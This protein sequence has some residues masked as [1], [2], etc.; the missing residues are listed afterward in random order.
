M[1]L[2]LF[3]PWRGRKSLLLRVFRK[4]APSW[5]ASPLRRLCQT[6]CLAAFLWLVFAGGRAV[7]SAD[8]PKAVWA[9]GLSLPQMFDPLVGPAASLAAWTLTTALAVGGGVLL[10]SLLLPRSFCGWVCPLGTLIDAAGKLRWWRGLVKGGRAGG[11]WT[12]LRFFVLAGAMLLSA[13][14][15]CGA[16]FGAIPILTRGLML[17]GVGQDWQHD[18]D[19]R[20]TGMVAG[21]ALAIILLV[22]LVRRR[23]WCRYVCPSGA[24]QSVLAP[25]QVFRRRVSSACVSCGQ[26]ARICEFGAIDG[27]DFSTLAGRCTF[28]Q[29]CG[30]VCPV[31]AIEFS[32][33]PRIKAEAP[34]A[35]SPQPAAAT[36][37]SAGTGLSRRVFIG[38]SAACLA[39][40]SGLTRLLAR[41]GGGNELIRPPGA[42]GPEQFDGLCLRCGTCIGVC[43]SGVIQPAPIRMGL[44]QWGSPHLNTDFSAC[45]PDCNHCTQV[46]PTG[47]I[48]AMPLAE[49]KCLRLGLAE[50]DVAICLP[51]SGRAECEFYCYDACHRAGH[52]A[53]DV[54][55]LRLHTQK[56]ND[57]NIDPDS[58]ML[59][60][61]VLPDLC[62]GCGACQCACRNAY[63]GQGI[64]PRAAIIVR[65]LPTGQPPLPQPLPVQPASS[66]A[67][68]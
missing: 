61:V 60:P 63:V 56:D 21:G 13:A 45:L 54:G 64:L 23:F 49:K 9:E 15:F 57:G 14:G 48:R 4:I 26:C 34:A 31:G 52:D 1:R 51:H 40:G 18:A 68:N 12:N 53:I 43:P 35:G 30:G 65:P 41:G 25:L 11:R 62:V 8:G 50:V 2:N 59:A 46:C 20:F 22:S 24:I 67:T 58:G 33:R 37:D 66:P 42:A 39:A 47:A 38:L 19:F 32:S 28:C 10:G 7:L 27:K 16:I 55:S 44:N 36:A 6:A 29:A 5:S 3:L 17:L